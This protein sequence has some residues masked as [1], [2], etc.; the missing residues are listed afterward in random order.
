VTGAGMRVFLVDG[1]PV[2]LPELGGI[3]FVQ[4]QTG[5]GA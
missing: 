5:A 2:S 4:E 1:E 3:A